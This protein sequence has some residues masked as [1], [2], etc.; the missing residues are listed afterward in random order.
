M[1][2]HLPILYGSRE[3]GHAYKVKLALSLLGIA[4]EYREVDLSVPFAERRSDFRHASPY[5]EVP[6]WVDGSLRLAQSNAIL[7][8]LA[9]ETGRLGGDDIDL[10]TQWLF[11][12]ANRIGFSVPNLRHSLVFAKDT[13]PEV[14]AW[15]RSR[16]EQDLSRL[17]L[18][19]ADSAFILG[20]ESSVVDV[21]CC[22][23]LF[24]PDQA[25]LDLSAW[26]NVA[27]WLDG[28]KS[29]RG[30]ASPYELLKERH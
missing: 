19:L 28:I 18:Q 7:I 8:H 29:L 13:A 6:V 3:S 15:L 21:A 30:W 14:V 22:A 25:N 24:W 2:A 10:V 23:Y 12:E 20:A 4:H 16:A 9:R 26:P 17:D 5:G 11:W 27:R 1:T